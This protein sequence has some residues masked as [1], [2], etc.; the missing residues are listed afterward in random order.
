[1]T[2][3]RGVVLGAV[4]HPDTDEFLV[5]TLSGRRDGTHFHRFIGG[6]IDPGE[7]STAA[8]ERECREELGVAVDAG[9]TVCTVENLFEFDGESHH[10]FAVVR[11]ATFADE[12]LYDRTEFSGVDGEDVG[13][14]IEYDAYWRSLAAL[15]EA[16]APFFPAGVADAV[17]SDEH[18]HVVSPHEADVAA[19]PDS[20]DGDGR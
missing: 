9:S 3:I 2:G 12:S 18:V 5:Q 6:G 8:L 17:A 14:R 10:E 7:P 11:E 4:R 1:M 19:L 13:E 15:T 16:D 20:V